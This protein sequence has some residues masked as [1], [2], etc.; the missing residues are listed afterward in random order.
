MRANG[1]ADIVYSGN[2][3]SG[4]PYIVRRGYYDPN[5][6]PGVGFGADKAQYK[7]GFTRWDMAEAAFGSSASHYFVPKEPEAEGW[8]TEIKFVACVRNGGCEE[9]ADPV[10]LRQIYL[11]E[12]REW[13]KGV[14]GR[15]GDSDT[16][17]LGLVNAFCE[18][19]SEVVV[20][21]CPER[22]RET[23]RFGYFF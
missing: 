11:T 7:H 15:N 10:T 13:F 2:Y 12:N 1:T 22:M 5:D 16:T 17:E 8:E 4:A 18:Q 9:Y 20:N 14:P 6:V 19:N 23:K 3:A 21:T